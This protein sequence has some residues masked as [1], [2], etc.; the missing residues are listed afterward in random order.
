MFGKN[1]VTAGSAYLSSIN[2]LQKIEGA[3]IKAVDD[4]EE[5]IEAKRPDLVRQCRKR[6]DEL[7]KSLGE[8]LRH[9]N[10]SHAAYWKEVALRMQPEIEQAAIVM[11]R[12]DRAVRAAA[13]GGGFA[14]SARSI[15]EN[16]QLQPMTDDLHDIPRESP[17]SAIFAE[18]SSRNTFA[19]NK[20]S[21]AA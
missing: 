20:G 1:A 2:S 14:N 4:M 19:G 21:N 8:A 13:S 10:N 7:F 3:F 9:A 15:V 5:A 6:R 12:Y 11:W 16:V 17:D 18:W